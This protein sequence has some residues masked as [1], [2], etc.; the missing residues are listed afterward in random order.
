MDGP[1]RS[2][3]ELARLIE[4]DEAA[5]ADVYLRYFGRV[6]D[7]AMRVARERETA[8]LVVQSS[9]LRALGAARAGTAQEAF[10]LQLFAGA[11]YDLADRL[12]GRR[13][14][15]TE[16]DISFSLA[17]PSL[18][19]SPSLA[20][21]LPA[22]ARAAWQSCASLRL[23]DY[24]LLDLSVRQQLNL[25]EIAAIVRTRPEAV[26]RRLATAASEL[27]AS[28]ATLLLLERGRQACLDLDFLVGDEAPSPSLQR[29][30]ARHLQTCL[31]CQ[32]TRERY[33][34]TL[35]M[36]AAFALVPAPDGW[37]Q[38]ILARLQE[39]LRS[40]SV[41]EPVPVRSVAL[42][43]QT[44]RPPV[45]RPREVAASAGGGFG[46]MAGG[47][48]AGAGSRGPLL[49]VLFGAFFVAAVTFG[50]LC[51]GGVFDSDGGPST[52]SA[53]ETAT[54]GSSATPTAT[55]TASPT[56]T[57]TLPPLAPTSTPPPPTRAPST[58]T[59]PR[60]TRLPSA[61]P[62]LVFTP[63]PPPTAT[64]PPPNP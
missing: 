15:P 12:R 51:A 33:P 3:E 17:D 63:T 43:A 29:R 21:E 22:L 61:T 23:D 50:A 7:Y 48:I 16:P 47:I 39:A 59:A 6:Y 45:A 8:A 18:A 49:L 34:G 14:P 62:I 55:P 42:P 38:T 28:F 10:R 40:G 13:E 24:E 36:L 52:A 60:P 35:A 58:A 46:E 31:T 27:E 11:H 20:S 19:G 30:V 37:Q 25:A 1:E 32:R 44:R 26:E 56:T 64:P 5:L 53:T 4:S 9:L 41:P 54:P 2:D 57:S